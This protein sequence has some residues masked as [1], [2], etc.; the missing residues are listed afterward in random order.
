MGSWWLRLGWRWAAYS[1]L[2]L[3]VGPAIMLF[4]ALALD[5]GLSFDNL[6]AEYY[7]GAAIASTHPAPAGSIEVMTCPG[8]TGMAATIQPCEAPAMSPVPVAA[9]IQT[10]AGRMRAIYLFGVVLSSILVFAM[11]LCFSTFAKARASATPVQREGAHEISAAPF[12]L[13]AWAC[14]TRRDATGAAAHTPAA[15]HSSERA[16]RLGARATVRKS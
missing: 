9:L 15:S 5:S 7:E 3:I 8:H 14:P 13:D 4:A 12:V 11:R 6:A 16:D 1:A 10:L 2:V